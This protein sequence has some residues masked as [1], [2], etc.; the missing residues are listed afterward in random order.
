[1]KSQS[2]SQKSGFR[3]FL[4]SLP[5]LILVF[6][7]AYLPL[8]GWIIAFF[9]YHP[10]V[11]LS[12]STFVGLKYFTSIVSNPIQRQEILRV[13]TNTLGISFLGILFSPLPAVF[14][15]FL[16]EIKSNAFRKTVQ[17][18]TTLP[19]FISWVIVYSIAWAMLSVEDGFVNRLLIAMNV[20]D[21]PINFL[22][23]TKH[24]WLTM[25]G[26]G[27]W[28]GLGWGAILYIASITSIDREQY[29]AAIVDGAGRFQSMWYITIPGILPTYFVLLLLAIANIINN[30]MEQYYIFM[31]PMNKNSIEVL[32][33]YVYLK[34]L[35]GLNISYSTAV[36]ILKSL[37]SIILLF[38]ANGLSKLVRKESIV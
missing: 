10:G 8:A 1:M 32:D 23:A 35:V 37:I 5:L 29:E 4:F 12:D 24:V 7:F 26:Y 25:T 13:M 28:K 33:L 22:T 21:T 18:L 31:N 20:I 17:T 9:D 34:G 38:S 27:I 16:V 30:G 36:G 14:A 19:N 6:V 11:K 15:L 2:F 3:L